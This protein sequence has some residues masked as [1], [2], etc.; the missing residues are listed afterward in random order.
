MPV[1]GLEER[2]RFRLAPVGR[3]LG[4][5][6]TVADRTCRCIVPGSTQGGGETAVQYHL[7]GVHFP[8]NVWSPFG[9]SRSA[10]SPD[11]VSRNTSGRGTSTA[12]TCLKAPLEV[13]HRFN[14]CGRA[15]LH[16]P[17]KDSSALRKGFALSS[18]MSESLRPQQNQLLVRTDSLSLPCA[19]RPAPPFDAVVRAGSHRGRPR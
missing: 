9:A 4:A 10:F 8:A 14:P 13:I 15:D 2:G 18:T 3:E 7:Q 19:M 17:G 16:F 6:Q 11:D 12:A 1:G 5:S